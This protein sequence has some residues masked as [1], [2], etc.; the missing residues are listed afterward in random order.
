MFSRIS[1]IWSSWREINC[2]DRPAARFYGWGATTFIG[3]K[4]CFFQNVF[5]TNCDVTNRNLARHRRICGG[6]V[7]GPNPRGYEPVF[8]QGGD[9]SKLQL[10]IEL[11][12]TERKGNFT[13]SR[14]WQHTS[15]SQSGRNRPLRDDFEGQG[16]NKTKGAKTLNHYSIIAFNYYM[17]YDFTENFNLLW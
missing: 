2:S 17:T 14:G 1:P 7:P 4:I 10:T 3:W 6:T 13:L 15:G 11:A 9:G 12:P 8:S 16:A 5:N